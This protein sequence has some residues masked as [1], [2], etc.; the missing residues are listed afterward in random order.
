MAQKHVRMDYAGSGSHAV[1][2]RL[3]SARPGG[4]V[5][6]C[7]GDAGHLGSR[8]DDAVEL[9]HDRLVEMLVGDL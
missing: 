2:D 8:A 1:V 5:G 7:T 3:L 9:G 4:A 6:A